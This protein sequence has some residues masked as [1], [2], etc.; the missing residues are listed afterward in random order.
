MTMMMMMMGWLSNFWLDIYCR[1]DQ[2]MNQCF[3]FLRWIESKTRG[4]EWRGSHQYMIF[5]DFIWKTNI[6]FD[7]TIQTSL[8]LFWSSPFLS[9]DLIDLFFYSRWSYS[10]PFVAAAVCRRRRRWCW[11]WMMLLLPLLLLPPCSLSSS[12]SWLC[13]CVCLVPMVNCPHSHYHPHI[14]YYVYDVTAIY[15][16]SY[17]GPMYSIY[18]HMDAYVHTRQA[19]VV[20]REKERVGSRCAHDSLPVVASVA[21]ACLLPCLSSL[22]HSFA[23]AILVP[24]KACPPISL[25][26]KHALTDHHHCSSAHACQ[27]PNRIHTQGELMKDSK[28]THTHTH[29]TKRIVCSVSPPIVRHT[30]RFLWLPNTLQIW[31]VRWRLLI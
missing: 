14:H 1:I 23:F 19:P 7:T 24:S 8:E 21:A 17:G 25:S 22:F 4:K 12:S 3:T 28:H 20:H 9:V 6:K 30:L 15:S 27:C 26:T 16:S 10:L 31:P 29:K 11:C 2:W 13:V 18:R 5:F